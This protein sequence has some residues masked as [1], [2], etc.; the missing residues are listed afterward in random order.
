MLKKGGKAD[1]DWAHFG[2]HWSCFWN[3]PQH[4]YKQKQWVGRK[5]G[6][7]IQRK[8]KK[9]AVGEQGL[10]Q[11]ESSAGLRTATLDNTAPSVDRTFPTTSIFTLRAID[12]RY[13]VETLHE[14]KSP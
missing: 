3:Q 5:S 2:K 11:R 13:K 1:V 8:A 4:F 12:V 10:W 9:L 6:R 14:K 7:G